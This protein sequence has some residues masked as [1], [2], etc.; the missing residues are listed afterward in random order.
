MIQSCLKATNFDGLLSVV[1]CPSGLAS[2]GPPL[3]RKA[4]ASL[5]IKYLVIAYN[6]RASLFGRDFTN[7]R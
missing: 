2:I 1:T 5:W 6:E 3:S 4:V 7:G